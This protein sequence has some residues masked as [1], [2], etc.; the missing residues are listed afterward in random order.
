MPR[1]TQANAGH[2]RLYD[3]GG[4]HERHV[5]VTCLGRN[6]THWQRARFILIAGCYFAEIAGVENL[7]GGQ[8]LFWL[9]TTF[10]H[11]NVGR[12]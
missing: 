10:L 12:F 8:Q 7:S 3:L 9:D 6:L 5:Q 4:L 2:D 1:T 11:N